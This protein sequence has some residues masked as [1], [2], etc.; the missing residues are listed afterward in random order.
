MLK[1]G[2]RTVTPY[3]DTAKEYTDKLVKVNRLSELRALAQ[4]YLPFTQ[5]AAEQANG[6]T[7]A[8]FFMWMQGFVLEQKG[9]VPSNAYLMKYA[10]IAVPTFLY[11]VQAIAME[12][13]IP[14][15]MAFLMLHKQGFI[16]YTGEKPIL[17]GVFTNP[18]T[19]QVE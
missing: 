18:K 12:N 10:K 14:W 1:V 11:G 4:E 16:E 8:T 9:S 3:D 7:E 13:K 19:K 5:D 6:L 17:S 15:G 2:K